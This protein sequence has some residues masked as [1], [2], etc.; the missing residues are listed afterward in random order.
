MTVLYWI[1]L[2]A[3]IVLAVLACDLLGR[4]GIGQ[5]PVG[6]AVLA[7]ALL[8]GLLYSATVVSF[9]LGKGLGYLAV[10]GA[11]FVRS[12]SAHR[13]AR[14]SERERAARIRRRQLEL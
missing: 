9:A 12:V 5:W 4:R 1:A 6:L 8:G 3:G 2:L 7:L 14:R 10:V 11:G 13:R